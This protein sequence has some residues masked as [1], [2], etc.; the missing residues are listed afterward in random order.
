MMIK[1]FYQNSKFN[2]QLQDQPTV[3]RTYWLVLLET[4]AQ[5]QNFANPIQKIMKKTESFNK[6]LNKQI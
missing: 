5:P 1:F 2:C 4:R 3:T 6:L